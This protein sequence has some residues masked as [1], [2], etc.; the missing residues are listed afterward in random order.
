VRIAAI[1][2]VVCT[3][4][5]FTLRTR[6]GEKFIL[7][8]R[9]PA[10]GAIEEALERRL[11]SKVPECYDA[12]R[13]IIGRPKKDAGP[14]LPFTFKVG[15]SPAAHVAEVRRLG[16]LQYT[17]ATKVRDALWLILENPATDVLDRARAAIILAKS[18]EDA[19]N[20][21]R[22]VA[23]ATAHAHLG[24]AIQAAADEHDK[25]LIRAMARL[26]SG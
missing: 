23:R 11:Y 20:R 2:E 1:E 9:N 10:E 5:E 17:N 8:S 26:M 15:L 19:C 6:S 22:L 12:L 18:C 16:A 14:Q 21:L 24:Q 25:A 13:G 3:P 7:Y 4:Y